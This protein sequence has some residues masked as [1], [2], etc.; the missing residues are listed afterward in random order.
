[1]SFDVAAV[2]AEFPLLVDPPGGRPLHYLDNAA[3]AQVPR[4][5]LDAIL[6]HETTSRANVHRGVHRLADA[7]TDAYANARAV[8]ARYLNAD[9]GE[10]IF[11]SGTTESIN[12]L[13]HSFGAGLNEDDEIVLSLV[14]HHSNLAPWLMLKERRGV[15]LRFLPVTDDGFIDVSALPS[16]VTKRC[17][18]IAVT[19]GSNVTGALT[20]VAAVV[21]AARGVGARV[22]LDGAQVAPHGPVDVRA[23]GVDFYAFSGHKVFGPNAIG[24]L[25]GRRALLEAM[26]PFMGGGGMIATATPEGATY[27]PPPQR[28]EAGTPAVAQAVGFGAALEWYR[29]LDIPVANAHVRR[30]VGRAL[31][32]LMRINSLKVIGPLGLERRLGVVSFVIDGAHPHDVAQILDSRGV[33]VRAGHHCAQPLMA[34]FDIVG[35]TRASFALY[36]TDADVDALVAGVADAVKRLV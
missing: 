17:K 22:L 25:W 7:A 32:G 27:Q 14:E 24:A 26:P 28:F 23:L 15:D 8:V 10:V 19:H 5:V 31:D 29:R 18:L 6:R 4:A 20:D 35:T 3:T 12:L 34:C 9:A 2:R 1:M 36:N 30:L 21:E 33:C 16:L 11:T 13:A